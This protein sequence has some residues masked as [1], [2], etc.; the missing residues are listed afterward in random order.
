MTKGFI[1]SA[2]HSKAGKTMVSLG[3][4]RAF[5]NRGLC[6][7]PQ[8]SGPDYIDPAFHARATHRPS[9]NLDS[10]A[11]DE[12]MLATH[13]HY[14]ADADITI[15]EGAMG[16]F[17]GGSP[18]SLGQT[19]A[20]AELA[21]RTGWPVILILD[22]AGQAQS[23]AATAQGFI[24]HHKGVHIAGIIL[25][26]VASP[27]HAAL[28]QSAMAAKNIDILG[29]IPRH[30]LSLPTR[31]LG[32]IQAQELTDLDNSL[33]N[34]AQLIEQNIDLD[35]LL[36]LARPCALPPPKART[37]IPPPA[38]NIAI[39]QDAAFSFLYPHLLHS[40]RA[41]G[42]ALYPFSPLA[43]EGPDPKAD[44]VW[45]GG[46]YP[47]L[48]AA[49]LS[50]A[51]NFQ[52]HM[53]AHAH[54]QT[55]PIPTPIHGECGGFMV[56]GTALIDAQGTSH[57]MLGLLDIVTSFQTRKL[58]LGYRHA[59]LDRPLYPGLSPQLYGHEFHYSTITSY[60]TDI[61][62][63]VYDASGAQQPFSFAR[64]AHISGSY[65]HMISELK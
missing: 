52:K 7:Q 51:Q 64:R 2:P 63:K 41:Q 53:H 35:R 9:Y 59:I 17:D 55:K 34:L 33:K 32:L 23:A 40:W 46:G 45:L 30:N 25:N 57:K 1:I 60:D 62:G 36:A 24:N 26:R 15:L 31:H 16:L 47:E 56:L 39:A 11:M 8:K 54:A 44:F 38:Q 6:V 13:I 20:T 48:H 42:A 3:L 22:V 29:I 49:R 28:I 21:M 58:N 43:D 61:Y 12:A 4:M 37:N 19:G 5:T 10:W 50:A 18:S 65:F 14:G 27:R